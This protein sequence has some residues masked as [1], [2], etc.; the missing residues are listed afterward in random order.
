MPTIEVSA[1]HQLSATEAAEKLRLFGEKMKEKHGDEVD[2]IE[3]RWQDHRLDFSL[4]A[5]GVTI[6][7]ELVVTDDH[8]L[9][10]CRLPFAAMLFRGRIERDIQNTLRDALAGTS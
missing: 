8:A 6:N 4:A 2:M 1:D 7:G 3:E 5:K 10:R 9:V